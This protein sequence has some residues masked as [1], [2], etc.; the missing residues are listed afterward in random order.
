MS[1]EQYLV[2]FYVLLYGYL[3]LF[4][5]FLLRYLDFYSLI[6]MFYEREIDYWDWSYLV[7]GQLDASGCVK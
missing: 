4:S 3:C 1:I 7:E 6:D 5:L 2:E